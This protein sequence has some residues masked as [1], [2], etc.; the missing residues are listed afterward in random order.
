MKPA[1]MTTTRGA[2]IA[3]TAAR[4]A[5]ESSS[6]RSVK[7]PSRWLKLSVPGSW[8][9]AA[10]VVTT[11]ASPCEDLAVV[12]LD[13]ATVHVEPDGTAAEHLVHPVLARSALVRQHGLLG[14]PGPGQHLLG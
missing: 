13:P 2:S 6:V 11:M 14:W 1:P 12:E 4:K 10:P 3:V 9:G 5:K 7:S 8:R